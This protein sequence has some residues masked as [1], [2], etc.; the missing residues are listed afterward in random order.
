MLSLTVQL[1]GPDRGGDRGIAHPG[2]LLGG[3]H[4]P[5][6]WL[7]QIPTVPTNTDYVTITVGGND[8]GF[9]PVITTC[10]LPG[11]LGNCNAAID[12]GVATFAAHYPVD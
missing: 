3:D 4:P 8:L 9:A 12:A 11:W 2:R 10:G 6:C 7:S 5:I 1:P